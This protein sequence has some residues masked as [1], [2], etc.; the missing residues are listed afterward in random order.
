MKA[1][2]KVRLQPQLYPYRRHFHLIGLKMENFNLMKYFMK[3]YFVGKIS[4]NEM[5]PFISKEMQ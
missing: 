2:N 5:I 4:T 1:A 3:I